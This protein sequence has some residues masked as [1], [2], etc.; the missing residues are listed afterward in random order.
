M[1]KRLL[2]NW[3]ERV[4][5]ATDDGNWEVVEESRALAKNGKPLFRLERLKRSRVMRV[6]VYRCEIEHIPYIQSAYP[7]GYTVLTAFRPDEDGCWGRPHYAYTSSAEYTASCFMPEKV[8][9]WL[10][11]DKV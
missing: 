2:K 5:Y 10:E 6:L 1:K 7:E 3:S 8:A 4:R 9:S 11:E